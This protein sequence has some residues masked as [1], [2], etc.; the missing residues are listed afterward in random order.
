MP[1]FDAALSKDIDE[2][3]DLLGSTGA[4]VI[5]TTYPRVRTGVIDG[6]PPA[7]DW[8]EFASY[9]V[10]RLDTFIREAVAARPFASVLD[11]RRHMQAWP[12]GELDP[13]K[14][15]DGI[16]PNAFEAVKLAEWVGTQ[17]ETDPTL[18]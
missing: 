12:K 5:W 15:P 4:H 8:P 2:M 6:V 17:L 7:H 9:R 1:D 11:V 10:D 16:H 3:T 14:R 13:V 18:R